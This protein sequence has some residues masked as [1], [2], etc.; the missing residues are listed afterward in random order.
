MDFSLKSKSLGYKWIF[1]RK[2][3]SNE[4]IEKSKTRLVV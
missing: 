4:T 3:K 2:I 1:N